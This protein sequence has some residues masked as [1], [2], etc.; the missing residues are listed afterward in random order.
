MVLK[1]LKAGKARRVTQAADKSPAVTTAVDRTPQAR[2]VHTKT[3]VTVRLSRRRGHSGM[4][5]DIAALLQALQQGN[6]NAVNDAV[7][8]LGTDVHAASAG[9][10]TNLVHNLRFDHMWHHA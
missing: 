10:I 9:E 7:G 5:N 8:A 1:L 4:S 6:T 3:P 2:L